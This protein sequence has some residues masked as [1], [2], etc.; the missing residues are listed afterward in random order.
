MF[1]FFFGVLLESFIIEEGF[2]VCLS[3]GVIGK[4]D[5]A[6]VGFI[7]APWA[8][9]YIIGFCE[10]S[11]RIMSLK[12]RVIGRQLGIV[13]VYVVQGGRDFSERFFFNDN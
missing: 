10:F 2:L 7:V 12:L 11:D 13:C 9:C 6:G 3:G 1:A 8:R 5:Y 4:R